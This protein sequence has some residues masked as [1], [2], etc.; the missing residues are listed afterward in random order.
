MLFDNNQGK[1]LIKVASLT[2][3]LLATYE[4]SAGAGS[5]GAG[6]ACYLADKERFIFIGR[7]DEGFVS[8]DA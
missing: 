8:F 4:T 3:E 7:T 6:L 2:G 1:Q 5:P